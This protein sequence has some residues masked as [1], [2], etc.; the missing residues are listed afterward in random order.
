MNDIEWFPTLHGDFQIDAIFM[1]PTVYVYRLGNVPLLEPPSEE[2]QEIPF[3]EWSGAPVY[4]EF[5][6]QVNIN[7]TKI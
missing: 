3:Y 1:K 6:F 2:F 7:K 5:E 4:P